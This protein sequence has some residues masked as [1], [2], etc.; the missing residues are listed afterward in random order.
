ML[1][2]RCGSH[3]PDGSETCGA[4]GQKLASGNLRQT[5]GTFSRKK[6]A[7]TR[8]EGA[9]FADGEVLAD[10]YL[11][12][13]GI[14]AGPLG[15]VFKAHD[16]EIDVD[17]A[18]KVI[19]PRLLQ[20]SEERRAF[21]R[22]VRLARKLS[23]NNIVRVYE[24]GEANDHPFFT[25]QYLD[26]LTLRRIIDLRREKNQT[27]SLAE[28]E[29]ILAQIAAGLDAAHK[30][31]PHGNLKPENVIVLPDLLKL[32]DFGIA[33]GLPRQPFAAAQRGRNAH[34][35]LA[36]EFL[37][38]HE[39]DRRADIYSLGVILGE[40]L[41]GVFPA[42]ASTQ[43]LRSRNPTLPSEI[44][45]LYRKAINENPLM[46][47]ATA[48]E[49]IAELSAICA[50]AEGPRPPPLE[51]PPPKPAP[52]VRTEPPVPPAPP[53]RVEPPLPPEPPAPP[54]PSEPPVRATPSRK[55]P[56]PPSER[57]PRSEPPRS[58]ARPPPPPPVIDDATRPMTMEFDRLPADT[59]VMP[60]QDLPLP[61]ASKPETRKPE[62]KG[63]ASRK[64]EAR[65]P[66]SRK[67]ESRRSETR[68]PEA[69]QSRK[70]SGRII[71]LAA[72]GVLA[73]AGVGYAY[74]SLSN[75]SSEPEP[76]ALVAQPTPPATPE[77]PTAIPAEP[78]P[79]PT[80]EIAVAILDDGLDLTVTPELPEPKP[81]VEAQATAEAARKKAEEERKRKEELEK[82]LAAN[83]PEK[84]VVQPAVATVPAQPSC[85]RGM[86]L[87]PAGAFKMGSSRDDPMMGFD[88]K[89][90]STVNVPAYCIDIYEY[91]NRNGAIPVTGVS[92]TAAESMCK[93]RGKR[94]CTEE[95]WEK[96]C[97]GGSSSRFPYGNSFDADACN[98]E[99]ADGEDR[100]V[101]PSGAFR[102]CRSSYGVFDMS[103]NVAE[104][105]ASVYKS[106]VADRTYKGGSADRPDYDAR[107]ASRKNGAP[108]TKRDQLGFRCCA[109]P[110]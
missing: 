107:C 103:G 84:K 14:G 99:D 100:V 20:T 30:V 94:L 110:Q 5:T 38:N 43:E 4:C 3:V 71:A 97:K 96:A 9:P 92:F 77:T 16:R 12:R 51:R 23:H 57:R 48:G 59:Q 47:H 78:T 53:A 76:P 1:C 22:E 81:D 91:P 54:V 80:D 10:R 24:D 15:F 8:L 27:F 109:D 49:L 73:G 28:V 67:P 13:Y 6:L 42:G 93:A 55:P 37:N 62:A 88:E 83:Q 2:Y 64:A 87:I 33:M 85:P 46:R 25:M 17:V 21:A 18:L 34:R 104:W 105:T 98:T 31:G 40:M 101:G 79:E 90:L 61:E 74:I 86:R 108:G 65:K 95:E 89:P 106:G 26:G 102:K 60:V 19:S 63:P 44:E 72:F 66:E 39:V 29:P 7:G 41:A 68:K 35:Y 36:P 52:P 58:P 69:R 50:S 70:G 32:T 45:G 56:R 82:A 75:S 11:I